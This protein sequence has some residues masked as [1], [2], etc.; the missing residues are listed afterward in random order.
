M[1][2]SRIPPSAA[3][4]APPVLPL[5]AAC[6][7]CSAQLTNPPYLTMLDYVM[8]AALFVF[9]VR[10]YIEGK[11]GATRFNQSALFIS[12]SA[13]TDSSITPRSSRTHGS[14]QQVTQ[15][16]FSLT[17]SLRLSSSLRSVENNLSAQN[18]NDRDSSHL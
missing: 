12:L 8:S 13:L 17:L 2:G 18:T 11:K 16:S 4:G 14:E 7:R 3:V 1:G 5:T 9:E 15:Y 10:Q 6:R